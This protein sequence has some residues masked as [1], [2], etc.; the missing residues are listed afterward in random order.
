[1]TELLT[2]VTAPVYAY[3]CL[4]ALLAA[5]AFVPIVPTQA[6]M[7]TAGALTVY[8]QLS[9][10]VTIGVGALGVLTGDLSCY[11]L[12]RLRPRGAVRHVP[13]H[14]RRGRIARLAGNLRRPGPLAL[15]L[16][17]FLPG[18]RMTACFHAGRL[19]YPYRRF[20]AYEGLAALGWSGYGGLVGHLGGSAL[21]GSGWW[22]ALIAA[23]A[24][25]AF[26]LL[27]WVLSRLGAARLA[28]LA[29]EAAAADPLGGGDPEVGAV[30]SGPTS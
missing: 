16:C 10:P 21:A 3:L 8:G 12:G 20:L 28:R 25:S 11:L 18:G 13:R 26:G 15:L 5:D 7:I 1:M 17:R 22:L 4:L 14:A 19:R 29:E 24:A 30:A 27:G 2:T 6:V 23:L 9:L